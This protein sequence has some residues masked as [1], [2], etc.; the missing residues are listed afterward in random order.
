LFIV[1]LQMA[2]G[3]LLRVFDVV[4]EM[5]TARHPKL[6]MANAQEARLARSESS[7]DVR[8]S[9]VLISGKRWRLKSRERHT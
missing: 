5:C 1:D 3:R 4:D 2:Q 7:L 9:T 6:N 8:R